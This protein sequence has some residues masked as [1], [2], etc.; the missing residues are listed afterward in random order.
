MIFSFAV[1][2]ALAI[3][4][5]DTVPADTVAAPAAISA[6]F[7]EA[8]VGVGARAIVDDT[9]P[10]RRRKAI[11][12]SDS[13]ALRLKIHYIASYATIPI[14]AAQAIVGEQLY[15]AENKGNPPP[16]GM[17]GAHDAIAVALAG[18][19]GVNTITGAWNWWETRHQ[20]KGRTWRTVHGALM[21]LADAGFAYTAALGSNAQFQRN[22]GNP[23]R[24]LHR[25]WAEA[26]AGVAL[27]SYIMM[28]KPFR[29]D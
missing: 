19:F 9:T 27:A 15:N 26:S 7:I 29:R 22:G 21:L 5:V 3:A 4:P 11:E 6:P 8:P 18:L 28:W 10:S 1:A 24:D 12:V 14:F 17:K 20:E 23:A 25:N 2:T 16:A 13:Y